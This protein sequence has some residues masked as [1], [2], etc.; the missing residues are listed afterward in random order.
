MA[1]T[2]SV[3]G[4][5]ALT[6]IAAMVGGRWRRCRRVEALTTDMP[7]SRACRRAHLHRH[8][9]QTRFAD[10]SEFLVRLAEELV[11]ASSTHRT[12]ELAAGSV[13]TPDP[14]DP[15]ELR[16]VHN[17]GMGAVLANRFA[18]QR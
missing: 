7:Q 4:V 10:R 2:G 17:S 9:R 1:T 12:A 6:V 16:V 8:R 5:V 11:A 13:A 15:S 3:L 14:S 18:V